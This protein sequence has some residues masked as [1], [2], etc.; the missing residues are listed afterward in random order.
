M[1]YQ[2][3][4]GEGSKLLTPKGWFHKKKVG[5]FLENLLPFFYYGTVE[6]FTPMANKRPRG[7]SY[8]QL[9]GLLAID[10][11]YSTAPV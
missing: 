7:G 3:E 8:H 10:A 9:E 5:D 1:Q 2:V 6:Y 4:T 11:N